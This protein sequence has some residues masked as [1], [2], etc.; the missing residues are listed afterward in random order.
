MRNKI[1]YGASRMLIAMELYRLGIV[2]ES[3]VICEAENMK[4][5]F[6]L[7]LDEAQY[8]KDIKMIINIQETIDNYLYDMKGDMK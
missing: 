1:L 7:L 2:E 6:K 4:N 5:Y 3:A 8:S